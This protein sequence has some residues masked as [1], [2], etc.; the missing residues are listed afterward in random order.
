ML[1]SSTLKKIELWSYINDNDLPIGFL[2]VQQGHDT[3]DLDLLDLA[4][5]SNQLTDFTDVQW[6]IVTL[7]LSLGVDNVGVFPCL[8]FFFSVS[9][10]I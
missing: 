9:N 10:S 3:K 4:G 2:L 7:G 1:G 5:I 6:I 8:Y